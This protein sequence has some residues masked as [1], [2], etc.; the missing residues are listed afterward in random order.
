MLILIEKGKN[1]NLRH[2][3]G[4]RPSL[5][6][7]SPK[8]LPLPTAAARLSW[9]VVPAPP[10]AAAPAIGQQGLHEAR[11]AAPS[12]LA[13]QAAQTVPP[14]DNNTL[15][16]LGKH[17]HYNSTVPHVWHTCLHHQLYTMHVHTH[18]PC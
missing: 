16:G 5:S 14:P 6:L 7:S 4:H 15:A 2:S 17:M 11:P 8:Q 13:G 3:M 1:T 10:P 9:A 12:P 18:R